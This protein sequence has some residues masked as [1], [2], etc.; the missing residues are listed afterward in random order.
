MI[1]SA[2]EMNV[3]R[4]IR[5]SIH[6]ER[7]E[8]LYKNG[9]SSNVT[10]LIA[11]FLLTLILW[12]SV[13]SDWLFVW[14]SF[15]SA[16][17][18]LRGGLIL[19]RHRA[20]ESKKQD[21]NYWARIYIIAT[22]ILGFGWLIIVWLGWNDDIWNRMLIVFTVIGVLSAAVT[23]LIP[24]PVAMY[25][26]ALP[27]MASV[28]VLFVLQADVKNVSLSV[29]LLFYTILMIRVMQNLHHT[30]LES[31][32]MRFQNQ[33]LADRLSLEKAKAVMLNESLEDEMEQ[34]RLTQKELERHQQN[35]EQQVEARTAELAEAK[36]AAEAGSRAKSEFLATMSHEIRTPMNG[37]L[38]MTQ[39]LLGTELTDKQRSLAETAYSSGKNLL[40]IINNILDFSKIEARK[41]RLDHEPFNLDVVVTD[42]VQMVA[43]QIIRKR[44]E[45]LSEMHAEVP[46]YLIGDEVRLRQ[47]L[48][49][50]VSNAIKFTQQGKIVIKIHLLKNEADK[51]L[52]K[53]DVQD[54]GIGIDSN[55]IDQIFEVFTQADSS[56]SRRHEGTGLGLA[57]SKQLVNLMGG[58][59]GVDSRE[60]EGS[61][62]HFTAWFGRQTEITRQ[63]ETIDCSSGVKA[64]ITDNPVQMDISSKHKRI[65][66]VEDNPINQMVA[67]GMLEDLNLLVD[68]AENGK[69]ACEAA[70]AV[71]YD[72]ILMD[73]FMP[74]LDGFGATKAIRQKEKQLGHERVPVI[75][76]TAD[77]QK[78]IQDRC[79]ISGMDDYL[80]KPFTFDQ[81]SAV[82]QQWL[83]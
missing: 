54:D 77:V 39:L 7:T 70:A 65:L 5:E 10:V 74:E 41:L 79:K 4:I 34:H 29:A 22:A 56:A 37:V 16:G 60:G 82:I 11:S 20:A 15:M 45:L 53:F 49:N 76:L 72:L 13:S 8:L 33:A 26:Y 32:K 51:I 83:K 43:E 55:K 69:A 23:V 73:C 64:T 52:I 3:N 38:G 57:I 6:L 63:A 58:E 66:L 48:L 81:L 62:F 36:E 42:V 31:L 71:D 1:Q 24:Y 68:M 80:S 35:L 14:L 19:M 40:G 27:S 12:G 47:I 2:L 17:V 28:L 67:E 78:G 25:F 18:M 59:I 44:L 50:L 9:R 21:A 30:L 75:A 61:I 46:H